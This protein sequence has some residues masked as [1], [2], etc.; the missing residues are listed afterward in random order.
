MSE[1]TI[2]EV[3]KDRLPNLAVE[4]D[5]VDEADLP[6]SCLRS[7]LDEVLDTEESD[8]AYILSGAFG[9]WQ[10]PQGDK[11]WREKYNTL[12]ETGTK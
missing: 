10:T 4:L 3:L 2:L 7:T 9:W 6:T 5:K 12:L 8:T 1:K 11:F